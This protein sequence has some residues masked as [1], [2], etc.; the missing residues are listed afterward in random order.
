M[1][2]SGA[3]DEAKKDNCII[4]FELPGHRFVSCMF[5]YI[6]QTVHDPGDD[7]W[8]QPGFENVRRPSTDVCI[9]VYVLQFELLGH[10]FLP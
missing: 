5:V 1:V 6:C 8:H 2:T 7:S 9:P 3:P 4:L 10:R